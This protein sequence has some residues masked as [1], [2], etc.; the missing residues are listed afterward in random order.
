[1]A[2]I[3]LR[4]WYLES[5]EP[6]RELERRPHDLRL[7]K[8]SLLKSALR[9]D[10]LDDLATVKQSAWFARYLDGETVEFYIEG[11]G[12]YAIANID[13]NSQEIYFTKR[14]VAAQL[15]P[16]IFLALQA[17]FPESSLALRQAV[18]ELLEEINSRS[19][20]PLS[21]TE[22]LPE[23]G[24]SLRPNAVLL[25]QIRRSLLFIADGTAIAV[26]AADRALLSP[27]IGLTLGYALGVKK[28]EQIL[29][30][31]QGRS[32]LGGSFPFDL[33]RHQHGIW[34]DHPALRS[35]LQT[36]LMGNLRRLRL[37]PES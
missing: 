15:D 32:D 24:A 35:Q 5:Y 37:W 28:P 29:V 34:R 14:D 3:A 21:I 11:S 30:M 12:G 16:T 19:R 4:A 26:G 31:Q 9:A 10:F 20:I 2:I 27:A 7:S 36:T 17:D 33:P 13:L 18:T 8:N 23:T 1:M 22:L 6:L 25:R